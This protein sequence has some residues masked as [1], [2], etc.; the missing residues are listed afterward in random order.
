MAHGCVQATMNRVLWAT[1]NHYAILCVAVD[2]LGSCLLLEII[3]YFLSH[4]FVEY[5]C[6]FILVGA[7]SVYVN[8]SHPVRMYIETAYQEKLRIATNKMQTAFDGKVLTLQ[9]ENCK[10]K[11][12]LEHRENIKTLRD[13]SHSP[14]GHSINPKRS[15]SDATQESRSSFKWYADGTFS[16]SDEGA[17]THRRGGDLPLQPPC[18]YERSGSLDGTSSSSQ[19]LLEASQYALNADMK[20]YQLS[21]KSL[22]LRDMER[23]RQRVV[24]A[25]V[26][27][28][29]PVRRL[30]RSSEASLKGKSEVIQASLRG[31]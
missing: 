16:R 26:D 23:N 9:I 15:R 7:V 27:P 25:S 3:S 1:S 2:M 8:E 31:L 13:S 21:S 29:N 10:Q 5:L 19:E 24:E 30:T 4:S 20:M 17:Q 14:I 28:Q 18:R 11:A 6:M 22:D 12:V